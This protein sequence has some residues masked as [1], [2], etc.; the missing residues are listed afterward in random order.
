MASDLTSFT[1]HNQPK[2]YPSLAWSGNELGIVWQDNRSGDY[3]IYYSCMTLEGE[4]CEGAREDKRIS[5]DGEGPASNDQLHPQI[6]WMEGERTFGIVWIDYR[7]NNWEIYFSSIRPNGTV[8]VDNQQVTYTGLP[9]YTEQHAYPSLVWTGDDFA[10]SWQGV[11]SLGNQEIFF[12]RMDKEGILEK[13]E[14]SDEPNII[15][16]SRL[17]GQSYQPDLIWHAEEERPGGV[18][19]VAWHDNN[20]GPNSTADYEVWFKRIL[21]LEE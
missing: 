1:P 6:V 5:A 9:G 2:D 7:S 13:K 19:G 20:S 15:N 16:V 14:G 12:A 8:V 18:F 3:E 4:R 11:D 10:L 21:C 17:F